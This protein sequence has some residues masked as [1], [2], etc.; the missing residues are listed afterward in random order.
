ME[1]GRVLR[2]RTEFL[3]VT[4]PKLFR[5]EFNMFTLWCSCEKLNFVS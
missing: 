4:S 1:G 5:D 3:P 2:T